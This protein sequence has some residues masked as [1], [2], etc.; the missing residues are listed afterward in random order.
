MLPFLEKKED[1]VSRQVSTL[2]T[3][4]TLRVPSAIQGEQ[5]VPVK[6]EE[7]TTGAGEGFRVGTMAEEGKRDMS[8]LIPGLVDRTAGCSWWTIVFGKRNS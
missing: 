3:F 8:Y 6:D 7:A 4:E 2:G 1:W 5:V